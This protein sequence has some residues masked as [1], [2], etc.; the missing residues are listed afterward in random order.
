MSVKRDEMARLRAGSNHQQDESNLQE[1]GTG[2]SSGAVERV[3]NLEDTDLGS[4]YA[5][6]KVLRCKRKTE[7]AAH[8]AAKP[9]ESQDDP[10]DLEA[11]NTAI[12]TLGDYS[13]K[14][15]EDYEVG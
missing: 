3:N 7:I 14:S 1:A 12:A 13:L 5:A 10:R 4:T 11:I 6:R 9:D 8:V 2:E 15:S